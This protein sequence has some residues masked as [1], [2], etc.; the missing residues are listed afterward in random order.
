MGDFLKLIV[1]RLELYFAKNG[2]VQSH[3]FHA[4][5]KPCK[6]RSKGSKPVH[7]DYRIVI[8]I[9]MFVV[10]HCVRLAGSSTRIND[11]REVPSS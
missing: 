9:T 3:I 5:A 1:D 2:G 6:S 11:D 4:T 8:N 7:N 10:S